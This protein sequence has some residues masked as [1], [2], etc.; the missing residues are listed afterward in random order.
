MAEII[1]HKYEFRVPDGLKIYRLRRPDVTQDAVRRLGNRFGLRG[2]TEFGT[3][4]LDRRGVAYAEPSAWQLKLFNHSGGWQYRHATRWQK[5]DG[6]A[7]LAIEDEEA[8]R[9][10]VRAMRTSA[11]PAVPDLERIRVERLRV[12]H[13][14]RDGAHH[15]ERIVGVRVSFRRLLDGLAVDGQGGRTV[16]YVDH[17]REVSGIDHLWHDIEAVH[18]HVTRLRPVDAAIEEVRRRYGT[19]DGRVEVTEIHL[20]YWEL[21]WDADQDYLQPAYIASVRLGGDGF[22]RMN[23]I[24][25][26]AA[27]VNAPGPIEPVIR[28]TEPQARRAG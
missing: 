2:T 1:T 19:G 20:G 27:A 8:E 22:A 11:L 6:S 23:A 13:A 9:I 12:A 15:Q 4:T 7:N 26:V 5:D 3:F 24:V 16:V 21:G 17:A 18:E 10:A 14:Q 25:P 28:P